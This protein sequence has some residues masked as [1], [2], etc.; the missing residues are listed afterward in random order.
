MIYRSDRTTVLFHLALFLMAFVA[1]LVLTMRTTVGEQQEYRAIMAQATGENPTGIFEAHQ[2]RDGIYRELLLPQNGS[3]LHVRMIADNG[4]ITLR[5]EEDA[6]VFIEHLEN[7]SCLM[8]EELYY[9]EGAPMQR[10]RLVEA[11]EASY[12]YKT[13]VLA[14][15]EMTFARFT[16]PGHDLPETAALMAPT[17]SGKA[18]RAEITFK[19]T[20]PAFHADHLKLTLPHARVP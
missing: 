11:A 5:R 12:N 9:Q 17:L 8:Q 14:T 10:L 18:N 13:N 2:K 16:A 4:T 3:G 19:E 6:V 20:G 1:T 7:L 15:E